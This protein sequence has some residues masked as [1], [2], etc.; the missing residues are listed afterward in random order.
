MSTIKKTISGKYHTTVFIGYDATGKRKYKSITAST[1][2][3]VKQKAAKAITD[4][5]SVP[6]EGLTLAQA[7]ERYIDSKS[8]A[9]SPSTLREYRRA[10]KKDFPDLLPYKLNQLSNE[11]I[12][13]AVNEISAKCAPK[14]VRNKY[15]LLSTILKAYYPELKLNI[16]LPQKKKPKV[17]THT[18]SSISLLLEHADEYLRIPILLAA[19]GGL[20][21]SEICA[22]TP[23]DIMPNGVNVDKAKVRG[24]D[25]YV[26]KQPKTEAGYRF[27]PLSKNIIKECKAW[28]HFGLNPDIL[29]KKFQN[30]RIQLAVPA[31]FHKLRHYYGT[32]LL[33]QGI[34]L[35]TACS[36]GGWDDPQVLL[37][38][39][40]H[41][42]RTKKT[43]NKVVS[44][45]TAFENSKKKQA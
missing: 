45:F 20:R 4:G 13:T 16:R 44:I 29:N 38:I 42:T 11:I 43:D 36:Y 27:V 31:T 25:G 32:Q 6:Y 7:Y 14:T 9:L 22:L 10:A 3:E 41:E 40:A 12:Q 21:R 2:R 30:L 39:Y 33:R 26:V 17:F 15:Y 34:D 8:N 23:D 24:E 5:V 37:K 1:I 18:D 19:F 28:K 35:M